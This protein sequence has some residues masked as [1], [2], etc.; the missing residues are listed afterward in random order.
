MADIAVWAGTD[1]FVAFLQSDRGAPVFA[2]VPA[3]PDGQGD[4]YDGNC[5]TD[6]SDAGRSGNE[7]S[8]K[9]A[10]GELVVKHQEVRSNHE[11]EL[12]QALAARFAPL[13][14][15]EL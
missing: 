6:L 3:R 10:A 5:H 7:A 8:R 4:S 13:D 12:D 2:K 11:D 1:E 9:P 15:L 14:G